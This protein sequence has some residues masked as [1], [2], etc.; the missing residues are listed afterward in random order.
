[1]PSWFCGRE[2]QS[3]LFE[4]TIWQTNKETQLKQILLHNSFHYTTNSLMAIATKWSLNMRFVSLVKSLAILVWVRKQRSESF[5][6]IKFWVL[7]NS[8]RPRNTTAGENF[9]PTRTYGAKDHPRR[10]RTMSSLSLCYSSLSSALVEI[11]H[12]GV[13]GRIRFHITAGTRAVKCNFA[14]SVGC[15][16]GPK[17]KRCQ[18]SYVFTKAKIRTKRS[19]PAQRLQCVNESH[20]F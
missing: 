15:F 19:H 7:E 2:R 1:M 3:Q 13:R 10:E 20:P 4:T 8:Q 6:M 12:S 18:I 16:C 5:K 9:T 11:L 14:S 17:K